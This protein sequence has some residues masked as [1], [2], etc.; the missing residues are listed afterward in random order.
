MNLSNTISDALVDV[1]AK[2]EALPSFIVSKGGVT[3]SDVGKKG[4]GITRARV[5]GQILP[6]IPVWKTG[7]DSKFPGM[8]YIVFP[9][10]VGDDNSLL[11]VVEMLM[12]K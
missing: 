7:S 9:G 1:I 8:S 2:L 12:A 11:H 10:N 5:I 6:G 4:L 3:S